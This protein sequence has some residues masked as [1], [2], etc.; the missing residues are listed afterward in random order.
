LETGTEAIGCSF[1]VELKD[2]DEY[3]KFVSA[4]YESSVIEGHMTRYG[5]LD[6]LTPI[7]YTPNFTTITNEPDAF[8]RPLRSATWH[9]SPR[10]Y[11][12]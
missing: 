1:L 5:N 2:A 8:D 6:R 3:L 7:N 12:F 11:F 4:N 9:I 10:K